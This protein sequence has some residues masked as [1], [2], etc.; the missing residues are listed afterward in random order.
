M[1]DAP[2]GAPPQDRR[3]HARTS[4]GPAPRG[5]VVFV[6]LLVE[7]TARAAGL[8]D[9]VVQDAS[10]GGLFVHCEEPP[11]L[12]QR[13]LVRARTDDGRQAQVAAR[14]VRVRWGGR[15]DGRALPAGVA[16]SFD[17]EG[18]ARA[19]FQEL[20]EISTRRSG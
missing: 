20:I 4:A 7:G 12:G 10:H 3:R 6:D 9:D 18:P 17:D 8:A 5:T 16:L 1:T 13:L 14:V 11:R 19:R 2:A 15:R